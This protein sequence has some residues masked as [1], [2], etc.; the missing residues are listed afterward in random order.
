MRIDGQ[1]RAEQTARREG[2][3]A[4]P[5]RDRRTPMRI[6]T[7]CLLALCA[8][9][10]ARASDLLGPE[11]CRT[12]HAEA[13]KVWTASRH[14]RAVEALAPDQRQQPL[15]LQCHSR[16]EARSGA[17]FVTSVSCETCHGGGRFY[18]PDIVM[19]DRELARAFGL[20][21]LG[22]PEVQAA[23]CLS[24]HGGEIP[25][26]QP[27]ELKSA[28][29]RIDHWSAERAA[30]KA[31]SAATP[32]EERRVRDAHAGR[33]GRGSTWLASRSKAKP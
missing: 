31:R 2:F 7:L 22:K 13:Y 8:A 24:C 18:Q 3:L 15:C 19:R 27:F 30:R 17:A 32:A 9:L 11:S 10:P 6:P 4:A 21:D 20:V 1:C 14:A 5:D 25:S 33:P 29:E 28:L 23:L 12:C 26:A 16:D